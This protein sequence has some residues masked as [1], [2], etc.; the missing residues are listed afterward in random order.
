ME[1]EIPANKI[2]NLPQSLTLDSSVMTFVGENG[3][4][5]SA[6][7]ESIF[8]KYL[9]DTDSETQLVAFSS[10][11]N[12]SFSSIFQNNFRNIKKLVVDDLNYTEENEEGESASERIEKAIK[13]RW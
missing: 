2:Y 10:G 9:Q 12:E 11:N 7:L 1:I 5:K 13:K 6:I 3:C 4:G 8:S